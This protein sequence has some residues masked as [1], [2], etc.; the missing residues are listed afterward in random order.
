MRILFF[1]ERLSAGG[2]ER[3]LVQL[4]RSLSRRPDMQMELVVTRRDVHYKEIFDTGI[5]IHYLVRKFSK[6]DPTVFVRF[7][8]IV[9]R[10]RPDVLHVW[11]NMVAVYAIP[12]KVLFNIP[13]VNSQIADAPDRIPRKLFGHWL[14]FP[15]SDR[16]VANSRAGLTA[17]NVS[18]SKGTVIYNGFDFDRITVL[19]PV[20]AVR[21]RL[22]ILSPFVVGMVA[23]FTIRKDYHTYLNAAVSLLQKEHDI[24]FLCIG[25]GEFDDRDMIARFSNHIRMIG[26]T[27]SI[28]SLMNICDVG[29]LTTNQEVHGEGISNALLEFM[30]LCKP[31]V[32]TN[33]GGTSELIVDGETGYL[34]NH[35]DVLALARRIEYLIRNR[36]ARL[37]MGAKAGKRIRDCF[38]MDQME[39]RFVGVY[40]SL[41][42]AQ[43]SHA[44][45]V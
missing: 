36:K 30:A 27:N 35:K 25:S 34:V 40:E 6:K 13:M 26:P 5:V 24:T 1:T 32:G 41:M 29:V 3:R 43:R 22:Q 23:S 19:E 14:T 4:I 33:G 10:F 11:G 9:R 44:L 37:E 15:F 18:E 39:Q 8:K 12:A 20:R 38:G 7:M 31:V 45:G 2:K 16:I 42:P 21:N 28:E 17:Y